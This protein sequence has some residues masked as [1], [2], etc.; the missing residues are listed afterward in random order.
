[1]AFTCA[2]RHPGPLDHL[3]GVNVSPLL[4]TWALAFRTG[5]PLTEQ[6]MAGRPGWA[7]YAASTSIFLPCP[8]R[9]NAR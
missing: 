6:R 7:E 5:R 4:M 9:R 8:P 1:M 3:I 2:P